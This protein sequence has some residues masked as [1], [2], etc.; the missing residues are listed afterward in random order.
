[1][2]V[3]FEITHIIAVLLALIIGAIL[4]FIFGKSSVEPLGA[5][6]TIGNATCQPGR[7]VHVT[8][9]VKIDTGTTLTAVA[10]KVYDDTSTVKPTPDADA[11]ALPFSPTGT[12]RTFEGDIRLPMG[13]SGQDRV[14]VWSN[15]QAGAI[16]GFNN[17]N[18]DFG[19]CS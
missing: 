13:S 2:P 7:I 1:M 16:T 4:G 17:A 5:P 18:K 8:G 11:V 9:S 6:I 15:W 3:P 10:G 14:I 19:P 12:I